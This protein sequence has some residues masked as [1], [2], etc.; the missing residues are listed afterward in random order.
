M[1]LRLRSL[2]KLLTALGPQR[3]PIWRRTSRPFVSWRHTTEALSLTTNSLTTLRRASPL[4]SLA[5][6]TK[7]LFLLIGNRFRRQLVQQRSDQV[8]FHPPTPPGR[9]EL[10]HRLAWSRTAAPWRWPW[11]APWW[12]RPVPPP[13]SQLAIS[14]SSEVLSLPVWKV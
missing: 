8:W 1:Y 9:E 4:T 13:A 14:I 5:F 7:T 2:R 11:N 10:A 12:M 3:R 6:H